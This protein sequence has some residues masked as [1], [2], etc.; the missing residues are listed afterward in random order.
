MG[1][2]KENPLT[3]RI[4]LKQPGLEL[5]EI[6]LGN[7]NGGW[8]IRIV[9]VLGTRRIS[10]K[11]CILRLS[12]SNFHRGTD[13][14]QFPEIASIVSMESDASVTLGNRPNPTL[15]KSIAG[16]ELNPVRHRVSDIMPL[17]ITRL[18]GNNRITQNRKSICAGTFVA[19]LALDTE[20][21]LRCGVGRES[22]AAGGDQKGLVT[23]HYIDHLLGEGYLHHDLG[24]VLGLI[25]RVI[26]YGTLGHLGASSEEQKWQKQQ[27]SKTFHGTMDTGNSERVKRGFEFWPVQLTFGHCSL[28]DHTLLMIKADDFNYAMEN[29]RVVVSPGHAI[30]TYGQTSF[31]FRLVTEPMDEI[32]T[33]R[34]R[35]GMI[36]AERPRIL[37]PQYVSKLLLEGFGERARDFAG[38]MEEQPHLH[39]LRY[40]F[41]L[42]KT[43]L[44]EIIIREPKEEVLARL[45][46]ELRRDDDPMDALIEGIDDAWEVCLMKFS[47]DLIHRSAD[48]NITEWKRR[49][50]I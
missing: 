16:G 5:L 7:K 13:P 22:D 30:E 32:G 4:L 48:G 28:Y 37:A 6:L 2:G 9:V 10:T 33:I 1:E 15:M 12:L 38:W 14:C 40:G 34:L 44:S 3:Y 50:L 19:V 49:G 29:T 35:K 42:K 25:G 41:T 24:G 27:R 43:D 26:I 46:Q 11:R 8:Q 45:E 20:T 39:I 31:R 17:S 47:M 23:L 18:A 21:A 36:H